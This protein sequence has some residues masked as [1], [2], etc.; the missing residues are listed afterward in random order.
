MHTEGTYIRSAHI[1][2]NDIQIVQGE[3]YEG[4]IHMEGKPHG[5]HMHTGGGGVHMGG[6]Y[7]YRGRG[8]PGGTVKQRNFTWGDIHMEA[9]CRW[10]NVLYIQKGQL[11]G[12][13]ILNKQ[14]NEEQTNGGNIHMERIFTERSGRQRGSAHERWRGIHTDEFVPDFHA[15]HRTTIRHDYFYK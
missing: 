11:H 6:I 5:R 15:T 1:H 12:G 4:D 10:G 13:D 9:T 3:T 14:P 7:I 2:G 8:T